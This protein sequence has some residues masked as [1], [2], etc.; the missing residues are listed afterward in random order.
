GGTASIN[1]WF[2][3]MAF[4]AYRGRMRAIAA[5]TAT[6]S[7]FSVLAVS[8]RSDIVGLGVAAIVFALYAPPRRWKVYV[9]ALVAVAGLYAAYLAFSLPPEEQTA[10][11][12]RLS[13]LWNPQ[14]RAEGD[15]AGRSS[16]RASLL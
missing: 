4:E 3:F 15:Y 9:C 8:S 12:T 1:V 16:D 2:S 6:L 7:V 5:V 11:I 10:A 14:L 13:E